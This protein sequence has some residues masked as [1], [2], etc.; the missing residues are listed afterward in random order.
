M[1]GNCCIVF[2]GI[3]V[4]CVVFVSWLRII[5]WKCC[6]DLFWLNFFVNVWFI[7]SNCSV[8]VFKFW[9]VLESGIDKLFVNIDCVFLLLYV[10]FWYKV[11]NYVYI[12]EVVEKD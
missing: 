3:G 5:V 7:I 1:L 4:D 2:V 8:L 11:K 6:D 10:G 9:R 12:F